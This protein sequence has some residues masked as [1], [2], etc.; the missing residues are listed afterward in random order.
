MQLADQVPLEPGVFG[1]QVACEG[2][3]P[4]FLEQG[5]LNTL[6]ATVGGGPSGPDIDVLDAEHGQ[7]L[8]ELL[9]AVLGGVGFLT[10]VKSV[11]K[12]VGWDVDGPA[13][14]RIATPGFVG[15]SPSGGG[16]W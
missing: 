11:L 4:T 2:G 12:L 9:G 8:V 14:E 16:R 1:R 3:L 5:L 10:D 15:S 6:Y 13:M 7:G